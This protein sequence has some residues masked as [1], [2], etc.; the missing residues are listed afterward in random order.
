MKVTTQEVEPCELLMTVEAEP[1]EEQDLLKKAAKR[2]SREVNIPGFRRGKAPFN[3]IVRRFGWDVVRDEALEQ[4]SQKMVLDALEQAEV[5]PYAQM[6]LEEVRWDPLILKVRVPIKPRVKLS[7]DYRDMR[8]DYELVE[9]TDEDVEEELEELQEQNATW[10]PVERPSQIGDLISMSVTEKD[11][12][13]ILAENEAVEYELADPAEEDDEESQHPD[14]TTPLLKLSAGDSKTFTITYPEDY[15]NEEYAGKEITFEVEVSGVKVKELDPLD[16]D[17]AQLVSDF[18]TLEE[19]KENIRTS[20][21]ERREQQ[22]DY[23]LGFEAMEQLIENAEALEWPKALEEE[24]IDDEIESYERRLKDAGITLSSYLSMQNKTEEELREETREEV[25]ARLK[26]GL[27]LGEVSEL[28]N[29]DV[30]ESEILQQAK[31][32]ADMT[33][34][35]DE[36]WTSIMASQTQ[37]DRIATDLLSNKAIHRLAEIA[38]GEAPEL[39]ENGAEATSEADSDGEDADEDQTEDVSEESVDDESTEEPVTTEA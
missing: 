3:T 13:E 22:R 4:S 34:G 17:F 24:S 21:K 27:V 36:V 6:S 7:S 25:V 37:Q 16:D 9:V 8:L 33:G 19:L 39:D 2:I 28:E 10:T 23:D 20:I 26:R 1:N 30:S 14:L 11:G 31:M 15:G 18:E 29:L 35:S 38:K 32:I 5:V 12:D